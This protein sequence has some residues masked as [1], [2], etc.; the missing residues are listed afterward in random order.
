MVCHNSYWVRFNQTHEWEAIIRAYEI[1]PTEESHNF[2][3]VRAPERFSPVHIVVM[4]GHILQAIRLVTSRSQEFRN[5][6]F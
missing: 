6:L 1:F 3:L 4:A 2:L 5:S